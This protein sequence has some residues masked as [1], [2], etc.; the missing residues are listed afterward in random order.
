MPGDGPDGGVA[1]AGDGPVTF[2]GSII[3]CDGVLELE[4]AAVRLSLSVPLEAISDVVVVDDT[5][6]LRY[7]DIVIWF[8]SD[9]PEEVRRRIDAALPPVS[10]RPPAPPAPTPPPPSAPT[11]PSASAAVPGDA[12][13]PAATRRRWGRRHP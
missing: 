9:E 8:G 11:E 12:P 4:E 3:G 6:G 10:Q 2:R 7:G 1:A 13:A 5:V